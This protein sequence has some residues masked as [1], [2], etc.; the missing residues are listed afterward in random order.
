MTMKTLAAAVL[1]ISGLFASA[2]ANDYTLE[3]RPEVSFK[4][5]PVH[6]TPYPQGKRA[7]SVW[8]SDACWRDCKSACTWKME[9]CVGSADPD[10]CRPHLDSCDRTCQREC[11]GPWSGPLLGF[12]DW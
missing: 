9:Y 6:V 2:M 1:L 3:N 4:R 8:N 5:G 12:I 11:R 7:A 10:T